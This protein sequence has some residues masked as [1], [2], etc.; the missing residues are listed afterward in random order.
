MAS[1]QRKEE[2][3]GAMLGS[4]GLTRFSVNQKTSLIR[5]LRGLCG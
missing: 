3:A 5:R 4:G 1:L 2:E